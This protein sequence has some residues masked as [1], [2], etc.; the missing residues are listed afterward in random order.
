MY[1]HW[2]C[3]STFAP[4]AFTWVFSGL[5]SSRS[6]AA[7]W[8]SHQN[9]PPPPRLRPLPSQLG[10][11]SVQMSTPSAHSSTE[12][13]GSLP[14]EEKLL[15]F[16]VQ[17]R[18]AVPVCASPFIYN[19]PSQS[20]HGLGREGER[21]I[22]CSFT[23]Q[24]CQ[25]VPTTSVPGL[26]LSRSQKGRRPTLVWVF[27]LLL[28]VPLPQIHDI[29]NSAFSPIPARFAATPSTIVPTLPGGF[30]GKQN[31]RGREEAMPTQLAPVHRQ[32]GAGG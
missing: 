22:L 3:T 8:G 21:E 32:R 12:P 7:A 29:R 19:L 6:S 15:S 13:S 14:S 4:A 20:F 25:L 9:P 11:G 30:P 10:D 24:P 26:M 2:S 17:R 23:G 18:S 28:P 27:A 16:A 31:L 5:G 1:D